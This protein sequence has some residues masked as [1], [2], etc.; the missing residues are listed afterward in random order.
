MGLYLYS[1]PENGEIK[2]IFQSMS[3]PHVYKENGIKWQRIFTVGQASI[4]TKWNPD[5]SED[6]IRKS[7]SK[8]GTLGNLMDKSKELSMERESK[9]GVDPLKIQYN[10]NYKKSHNG[11]DT[12][13]I[14]KQKLKSYLD[15]KGF[16]FSDE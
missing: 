12:P 2:E 5:S 15:S 4:D 6:F 11:K 14:R 7:S 3:E 10:E 8:K 9:R 1:N 13:E 16:T